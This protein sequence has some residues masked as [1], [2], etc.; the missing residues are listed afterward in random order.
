MLKKWFATLFG[1]IKNVNYDVY[2]QT[3]S[4]RRDLHRVQE[5]Q[6][7]LSQEANLQPPIPRVLP[8]MPHP[9][10]ICN[11]DNMFDWLNDYID[12]TNTPEASMSNDVG[13]SSSIY[14]G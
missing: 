13:G 12:T 11:T 9:C 14:G 3:E 4:V 10:A 7:R 2:D 1:Y 5:N 8:Y 6:D